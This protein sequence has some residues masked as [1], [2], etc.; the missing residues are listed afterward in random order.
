MKHL[1]S[2]LRSLMLCMFALLPFGTSWADDDRIIVSHVEATSNI[3]D[4]LVYGATITSPSFTITV[5]TEARIINAGSGFFQKWNVG[6]SQWEQLGYGGT[7]FSSGKYRFYTQLRIDD[8]SGYGTTHKLAD[9]VTLTVNGGSWERSSVVKVYDGYSFVWFSSPE[10]V[11]P[12]PAEL[13]FNPSYTVPKSYKDVAISSY[14]VA[15]SAE[16]GVKPYTFSKVSGPE[17]IEVTTDGTISGT[18]TAIGT[19]ADL[20]IRV[21]DAASNT[22]E[23]TIKVD[24]TVLD[25]AL[26][27]DISEIEATSNCKTIAALGADVV[28]PTFNVTKGAPAYFAAAASGFWLKWDGTQWTKDAVGATFDEGKYRYQCQLRIDDSDGELYK[29]AAPVT[30]TVDGVSWIVDENV[31]VYNEYSYT[32]VTSDEIV[33]EEIVPT[34]TVTMTLKDG[35]DPT[36]LSEKESASMTALQICGKIKIVEDIPNQRL[37]YTSAADKELF[38]LYTKPSFRIE[39]AEGVTDADDI[40][41]D[42]SAADLDAIVAFGAPDAAA[43]LKTVKT[44]KLHFDVPVIPTEIIIVTLK[45]GIDPTTLSEKESA[46]M[47]ALQICGKIK[48]VE[49]IPNQRLVY[50]SAEDKELFYLYTKPSFRIELAEGV[51]DA[52]DITYDLSAADLD[53]IVAFGAP[54][55]AALLKTVKT[56]QLHFDVPVVGLAIDANNFPDDNFRAWLLAQPYG[57]DAVLTDAEIADIK[58]IVVTDKEIKDLTGIEYFTAL[59]EL[60][61]TTNQLKTLDVS[62]NT[63]LTT[64]LCPENLLTTLDLSKNTALHTLHCGA[65]LITTLDLTNNTALQTLVC[66]INLIDETEMGKLVAS[67]PSV[68][69]GIFYVIDILS[70][71]EGNVITT[72]QVA[73]AK[74]KGWRVL[75]FDGEDFMDYP[76]SIPVGISLT[77]QPSSLSHS[78]YNIA[79]Q[80]QTQ[81]RRG[82][83]IINGRKVLMK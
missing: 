62:K 60:D 42:L 36:T 19:N 7:T 49:D 41:Y 66:L 82:V 25:P 29:L 74:A 67:L 55:A 11:I 31:L 9:D 43:L 40:T 18:P 76:G 68:S 39:L 21:T 81:L 59:E 56:I 58:E 71:D 1:S 12:E 61:C 57:A 32:W 83:N 30:V 50:T 65:N 27:E 48:I 80:R 46:S 54:D 51:T 52:D 53:A 44:I 70:E 17:W 3:A 23:A 34:E 10:W 35:T 37:V 4:L 47:T 72:E 45:D 64:L 13:G 77:T 8:Y 75:G 24:R 33:L 78:I 79:G 63:A 69:N 38:Y 6:E 22:A 5:G 15:S 28:K 20:V 26:R 73:A 16:G 14:N 2:F